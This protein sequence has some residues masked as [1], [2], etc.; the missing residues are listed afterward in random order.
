MPEMAENFRVG[1]HGN[2]ERGFRRRDFGQSS[3]IL[4]RQCGELLFEHPTL[5]S[6]DALVE[7]HAAVFFFHGQRQLLRMNALDA[8]ETRM[9][10][11]GCQALY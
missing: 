1:G 5:G 9:A 2:A 3:A 7:M 6:R 10:S 4:G 11:R 8:G